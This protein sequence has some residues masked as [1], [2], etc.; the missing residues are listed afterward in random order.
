MFL[1]F[2]SLQFSCFLVDTYV[3]YS[4]QIYEF[5][6]IFVTVDT[7]SKSIN[8]FHDIH[9]YQKVSESKPPL[10]NSRHGALNIQ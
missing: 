9:R 10:L 5:Y 1:V 2:V 7:F 4:G 8:L 3:V 6:L